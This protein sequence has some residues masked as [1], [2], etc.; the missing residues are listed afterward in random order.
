MK[1]LALMLLNKS[2]FQ[3]NIQISFTCLLLIIKGIEIY[4]LKPILPVLDKQ[5]HTYDFWI[6]DIDDSKFTTELQDI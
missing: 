5:L 6:V 2:E 4:I 1:T 3:Y